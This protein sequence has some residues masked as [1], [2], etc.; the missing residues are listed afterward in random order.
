MKRKLI[1]ILLLLS[2]INIKIISQDNFNI[3]KIT[4]SLTNDSTLLT[5]IQKVI[6]LDKEIQKKDIVGRL[7]QE[8]RKYKK[9]DT[10]SIRHFRYDIVTFIRDTFF[11]VLEIDEKN[12]LNFNS[13]KFDFLLER[14]QTAETIT[15]LEY[16]LLNEIDYQENQLSSQTFHSDNYP[17]IKESN[18][19]IYKKVHRLVLKRLKEITEKEF[20]NY[21]FTEFSKDKIKFVYVEHG[22]DVFSFPNK[23][24]DR[25][26]TG[27][28]RVEVGTDLFKLRIFSNY[29]DRWWNLNSRN[30]YSFQSIFL[31]GEG[32]T[33]YLRDT[34]IFKAPGSYDINDR[35]Y[36]S[37]AYLGRAKY[38]IYRHG[39]IRLKS[40]LKIGQI[41]S[42]KGDNIQSTIHRDITVGSFKPNGWKAQIASGGRL[43]INLNLDP[44]WMLFSKNWLLSEK[45]TN[46]INDK[47]NKKGIKK[48]FGEEIVNISMPLE[49]KVGH[50]L[51]SAGLGL[52]FSTINFKNSGGF[53]SPNLT[54][55]TFKNKDWFKSNL[56]V[57]DFKCMYRRVL[58]NSMLEGYGIL[59]HQVDENPFSP[60]DTHFL[61]KNQVKRNLLIFDLSINL[62]LRYCGIVYKST[63]MSSEYDLPVNSLIYKLGHN[64]KPGLH[65]RALWNHIGTIGLYFNVGK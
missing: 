47:R 37:Y 21:S 10:L 54:K 58:H 62:K 35:P 53:N 11:T 64:G 41:G 40:E 50:D 48:G 52:R 20:V 55:Q 1:I 25:D 36:A 63:I 34:T 8:D 33:P 3:N 31:G 45:T 43:G 5:K 26:M 57:F 65:N 30:W 44:E 39:Q 38:R 29:K 7:S 13:E 6:E 14:I 19:N 2:C 12:I 15:W 9:E 42:S 28:F 51:T 32:Y 24:D 60:K 27:S 46:S 59:Y 22:N 56:I 18:V 23:N 4:Y 17:I 49:I 16:T 61:E